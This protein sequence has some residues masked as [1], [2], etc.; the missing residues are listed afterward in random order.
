MSITSYTIT[1]KTTDLLTKVT[2][3]VALLESRVNSRR[4]FKR[5]RQNLVR[6]IY[7]SISEE[8]S[9]ISE[10]EAA[11]MLKGKLIANNLTELV[12]ITNVHKAYEEIPS[13][14][15]YKIEDFL[16]AHKIITDGLIKEAGMFRMLNVNIIYDDE[17]LHSGVKPETIPDQINELFSWAKTADLSPLVKSSIVHGEIGRIHP[18]VDG[19]GRMGRL[20][21]TVILNEWSDLFRWIPMESVVDQRKQDYYVVV[22]DMRK[23]S[24][25]TLFIEFLVSSLYADLVYTVENRIPIKT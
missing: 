18:F 17:I 1:E 21:Q 23:R 16:R 20:W 12:K 9:V 13:Y 11:D 24:D 3:V 15:P 4:D 25:C 8:G 22:E 7:A 6:A 5:Y 10:G 19:N 14:D 2:D